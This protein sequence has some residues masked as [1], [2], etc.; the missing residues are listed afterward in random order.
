MDTKPRT[1]R[2]AARELNLS[3]ST[4]RAWVGQRRIGHVKLGRSI[5]VPV[6]EIQRL[7]EGGYIP[8]ERGRS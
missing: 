2:E 4:I 5:R 7:L 8:P 1:I 3:T 6:G